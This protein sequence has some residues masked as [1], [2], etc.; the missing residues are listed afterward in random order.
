MN[1]VLQ[2]KW[3]ELNRAA[4]YECWYLVKHPAAFDR[5]CY[6]VSFLAEFK[7]RD[8]AGNL[9]RFISGKLEELHARKPEIE[10]S[11]NY[12]TLRVAAFF[13][14]IRME[15][16]RYEAAEI[17]ETF[18]EI[19]DRC[20][21]E[22]ER[23]ELYQDIIQRQ[24][25]KI[26][27]SS[28]VDEEYEGVRRGYRLYPVM[29]LYKVLLELGQ[30]TG[31]YSVSL[32][33][34]RYLVA[35]TKVFEDF[36][37]TL[38]LIRLFREDETA[39]G[40]FEGFRGKFDNRFIQAL[41]QLP[42]LDIDREGITLR[43]E[44]VSQVREKV[45]QYIEEGWTCTPDEYL[46]FL[47][48]GWS[49]TEPEPPETP[50]GSGL[51][52]GGAADRRE[53]DESLRVSTGEN[54]LLYGVPGAGK[55]WI[56]EHEYCGD[57]ACMERLVFHPDYL[58][59]DFVGQIRPAEENGK[60]RYPFQPGPFTKILRRAYEDPARSFFL[61]IEEINR[62]NAPAIFG[63]IFQLLDRRTED[64]GGYKKCTS[65]YA[66]TAPDI[67]A[68]V[69]GDAGRKVRIPANL[70]IIGTMNTSDQNVFT[71][72]T[73]FQRRWIM[74][75]VP[76]SFEGHRY[77]DVRILDT[78]VSWR[79]FCQAV[80]GEILRRDN[81]SSA[82]DKRM[83]AY[84]VAQDDLCLETAPDGAGELERRRAERHNARFAEKVLKY[85]WD[86]AFR[87]SHGDAFDTQ[88]Y[89]SLEEVVEGFMS[90]IGNERFRV[91]SEGL[92]RAILGGGR[93]ED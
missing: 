50:G 69:Y 83:G 80:N 2:K 87:F 30:A 63:E 74:R 34:Y 38:L 11:D 81:I 88:R 49:L 22:F 60:I 21:G 85:L 24:I 84:F 4:D 26:Y 40:A 62:G 12:R 18:A 61:V 32:P 78:D 8:E 90:A 45:C 23:T 76:N 5:L 55:S 54:I 35:T 66:I 82:E 47:G 58:Y 14:L 73:A 92:R 42:T 79:Q 15:S 56:I 43:A 51:K 9:H 75:M 16:S 7:E 37:D 48:S 28:K 1:P 3:D 57:D 41:K 27:I 67:A 17:T 20:G 89:R 25:E 91:C 13:G 53:I 52:S 36:L 29:L 19:R 39:A 70:S 65:E 71:L 44:A 77:A 10:I 59:S 86:D 33:E 93:T 72:D 6:L 31:S 68:E 64:G 46:D